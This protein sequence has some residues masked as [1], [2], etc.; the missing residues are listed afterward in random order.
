MR[1]AVIGAG[2]WGTALGIVAA[3]AGREVRLWS[4]NAAVVADINARR[5]NSAYLDGHGI[6]KGVRASSEPGEALRG[7]ELVILAAPSHATRGVVERLRGAFE[8]GAVFVGATKGIEVETGKRMSEVVAEVLGVGAEAAGFVCLS[9]PSFAQEVAAGQPTAV[10]AACRDEGLS[11]RVQWALSAQ[12]FRVYT[13]PDVTGTELGG[14]SKNVMA[15]A[16]GMVAGLRLGTN[17]VA[18]LVTRGLAE[19]TRLALAEGG[20]L[21]TLMGLAGLGDLVLTCTGSLSRNRYVGAELGRG[22][23]LEDVLAGMKEVAEGVRTTRAVRLIAARRGVEMPITEEVHAVLY[24]GKSA[25][26]AVESLMSRPLRNESE[27]YEFKEE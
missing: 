7:A 18:A 11:R 10:V 19:M 13:N 25:R 17:S 12:N 2:G 20:R 9:G 3:R 15:L 6:P 26:A 4:R 23:A 1:V 22:R 8:P 14:A 16:A 27:G 21:E 24:E 5:V